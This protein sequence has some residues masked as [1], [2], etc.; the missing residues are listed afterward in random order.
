VEDDAG[1]T[2]KTTGRLRLDL[3]SPATDVEDDGDASSTFR[4]TGR[5][6]PG[7]EAAAGEGGGGG[8]PN[9]IS[10]FVLSREWEGEKRKERQVWSGLGQGK[11]A[12]TRPHIRNGN[13]SV[14]LSKR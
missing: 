4:T 9:P 14:I 10:S 12:R 6:R 8:N 3:L 7:K 1:A 2:L 5:R 11:I 13:F